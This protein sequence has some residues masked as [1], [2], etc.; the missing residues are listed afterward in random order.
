MKLHYKKNQTKQSRRHKERRTTPLIVNKTPITGPVILD[1]LLAHK[2]WFYSGACITQTEVSFVKLPTLHNEWCNP[3]FK[4]ILLNQPAVG[5]LFKLSHS[6]TDKQMYQVLSPASLQVWN[7]SLHADY[8]KVE[9]FTNSV[10]CHLGENCNSLSTKRP[11][12]GNWPVRTS[13][14]KQLTSV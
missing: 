4:L 3:G 11:S 14:T 2:V 10:N 1:Q 13:S 8:D 6:K 5:W 12:A 7:S 9:A